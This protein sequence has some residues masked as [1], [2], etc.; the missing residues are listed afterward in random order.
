MSAAAD[1]CARRIIAN[2]LESRSSNG[3]PDVYDDANDKPIQCIG[4][5]TIGFGCRCRGWSPWL[6]QQ[7]LE[8]QLEE[9][10]DP[11]LIESWY[12]GCDDVRRSALLEVAFNQGDSGLE[13]GYPELI[14]AVRVKNWPRAQAAC[15]VKEENVRGRYARIGLILLTGVSV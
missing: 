9:K 13:N 11:L 14:A 1:I 12:Q 15:T 2:H 5:P 6:C 7:V 8:L 10:E 4:Q 3:D